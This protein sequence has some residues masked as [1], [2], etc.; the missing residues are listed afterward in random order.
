MDKISKLC[1][2]ISSKD[3]KFLK[4]TVKELVNKTE[5]IKVKKI[6]NSDFYK[7]RK[8][9][10]RIIFHYENNNIIIDSIKLRNEKTYKNI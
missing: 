8:G 1:K 7:T 4:N 9:K 5:N 6:Q 2:K 10:F 3:R